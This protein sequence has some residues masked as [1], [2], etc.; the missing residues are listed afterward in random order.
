MWIPTLKTN[1][2][3]SRNV[4]SSGVSR[5]G[6]F[7]AAV[8]GAIKDHLNSEELLR[9]S[10][11]ALTAGGGVFAVLQALVLHAGE[12]FPAP[13]DAALATAV[14]TL[15]L[16]ARRRLAQGKEPAAACPSPRRAR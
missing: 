2:P 6:R 12:V 5:L 14:L 13:A 16:E 1:L 9:V 15:I 4:L 11:A 7:F 3:R 10:V 8:P